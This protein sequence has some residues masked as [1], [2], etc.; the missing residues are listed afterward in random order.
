[1]FN[2]PKR[3][4][5]KKKKKIEKKIKKIKKKLNSKDFSNIITQTNPKSK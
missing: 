2:V 5:K 4:K 1:V 3:K